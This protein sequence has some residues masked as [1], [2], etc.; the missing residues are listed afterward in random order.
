MR[1]AHKIELK[2][3]AKSIRLNE[4]ILHA[5]EENNWSYFRIDAYLRSYMVAI[6]EKLSLDKSEV[7]RRLAFE[8]NSLSSMSAPPEK[9]PEQGSS[10]ESGGGSG[11]QVKIAVA[12]IAVAALFFVARVLNSESDSSYSAKSNSKHSEEPDIFS[13]DVEREAEQDS[14]LAEGDSAAVAVKHEEIKVDSS[15]IDTLRFECT[16]AETDSTCGI[17]LKGLDT[18][19]RYFKRM[20]RRYITRGDT[21]Q[22]TITVPWRTRL[23]LNSEKLDYNKLNTVIF[24]NGEMV[25]KYN[26]ELK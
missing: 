9:P 21:S 19:M 25:N 24:Y 5:I 2:Q 8:K 15:A 17:S 13:E 26:R 16:P 1:V 4:E 20:E 23:F 12:L 7:L 22:I 11:I 3:M 10:A 6:C 14:S 18:K